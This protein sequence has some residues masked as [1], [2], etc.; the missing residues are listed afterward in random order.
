M[1]VG[2]V[3]AECRTSQAPRGDLKSAQ[4]PGWKGLGPSPGLEGW[5][6]E[7]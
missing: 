4:K 6:L 5:D 1:G 2:R 3:K 7:P